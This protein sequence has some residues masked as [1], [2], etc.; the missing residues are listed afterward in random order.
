MICPICKHPFEKA[1][2]GLKQGP[3]CS[4]RCRLVDLGN[5]L[6]GAYRV[7]V[8]ASDGEDDLDGGRAASSDDETP[9]PT[10]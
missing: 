5:W 10:N 1:R 2:D 7:S 6:D 3:F 9:R 4:A 8:S